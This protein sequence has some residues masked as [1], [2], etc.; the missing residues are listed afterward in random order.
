MV[1]SGKI[2]GN[3][4]CVPIEEEIRRLRSPHKLHVLRPIPGPLASD[5][6][7]DLPAGVHSVDSGA[8]KGEL[9]VGPY[10]SFCTMHLP[11]LTPVCQTIEVTH[12][13]KEN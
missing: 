5:A 6:P 10:L 12:F 3:E 11:S 1:G 13:R 4:L 9:N 8:F 2:P 7:S